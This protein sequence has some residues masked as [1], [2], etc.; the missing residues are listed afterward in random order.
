MDNVIANKWWA[1]ALR[2]VLAILF[3]V[4][5]AL[6]P[7]LALLSLVLLFGA[8]CLVDGVF[9]IVSGIRHHKD[10]SHWWVL[11]L[12]G[13]VGIAVGILTFAFPPATALA[14]V[15]FVAAWAI[16]TG[17]LEVVAAIR[18]RKEIAGEWLLA[19]A[20]IVSVILGV[21]MAIFPGVAAVAIVW[22]IA[23]YAILFGV[24]ML[25][26]AFKL[27]GWQHRSG[28]MSAAPRAS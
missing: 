21:F 7:T 10:T 27:R 5:A 12:E 11:V 24:I 15:Y 9:A 14:L 3:G 13:L 20:G 8:Y 16:V 22:L 6:M 19:L 28:T 1:V 2:G 18:L 23:A 26:L 25:G 4:L 17:L